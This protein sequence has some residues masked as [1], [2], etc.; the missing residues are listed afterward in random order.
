MIKEMVKLEMEKVFREVNMM[1]EEMGNDTARL[2]QANDLSMNELMNGGNKP[3]MA[4]KASI[5][6]MRIMLLDSISKAVNGQG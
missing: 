5:L 4:K 3:E 1:A 2:H 6:I